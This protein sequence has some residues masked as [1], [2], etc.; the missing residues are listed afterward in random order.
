MAEQPINTGNYLM[1]PTP[2]A[3]LLFQRWLSMMDPSTA[4][5]FHDQDSLSRLV[6]AA[7]DTCD[8][9]DDCASRLAARNQSTTPSSAQPTK[10][11]LRR[12]PGAFQELF[13]SWCAG[14]QPE[15]LA[16]VDPCQPGFSFAYFHVI[17]VTGAERKAA[18]L[19]GIGYWFLE[20]ACAAGGPLSSCKPLAWSRP[21][22]EEAFLR[23]SNRRVAF[24][25]K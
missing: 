17:C 13:G 15:K 20:E 4:L 11:L 2:A 22:V 25:V 10:A 16:P 1:L 8:A 9:W 7:Y 14:G 23:C 21:G 3:H 5:G 19:K 18:G 6:M 24:N 12:T